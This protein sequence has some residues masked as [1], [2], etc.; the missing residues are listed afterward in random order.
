MTL[1]VIYNSHTDGGPLAETCEGEYIQVFEEYFAIG[2]H[3]QRERIYF[4]DIEDV[5]SDDQIINRMIFR[6]HEEGKL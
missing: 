3:G 2:G 5:H 1:S 6:L 4:E